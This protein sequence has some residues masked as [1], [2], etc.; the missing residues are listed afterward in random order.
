MLMPT[1][2]VQK[3]NALE[4]EYRPEYDPIPENWTPEHMGKRVIEAFEVM[5]RLPKV[6]GPKEPGG[7]WPQIFHDADD[8]RGWGQYL[9]D[10]EDEK[11]RTRVRPSGI[12][13]KRMEIIFDWLSQ[14][15]K[16]DEGMG[17]IVR[18]WA[19]YR[20]QHRSI[21]GLCKARGWG[22][23]AFYKRLDRGLSAMASHANLTFT[24]VW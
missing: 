18:A 15:R 11:N 7:N 1:E 23:T 14:L 2:E 5:M 24:S 12:E 6:P 21:R 8:K 20:S 17:V 9:H 22:F 4:A 3:I 19:I 16:T 10:R 13:I